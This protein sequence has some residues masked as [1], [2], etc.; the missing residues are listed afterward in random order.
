MAKQCA[1]CG[2]SINSGWF[3]GDKKV[4][5]FKKKDFL[6][7]QGIDTKKT[8]NFWGDTWW[9]CKSCYDRLNRIYK[10]QNRDNKSV[11]VTPNL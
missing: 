1:N 9:L 8:S 6:E 7:S 5:G 2:A 11:D 4:V 10:Y 3:S